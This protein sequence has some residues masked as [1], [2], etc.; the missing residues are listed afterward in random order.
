MAARRWGGGGGKPGCWQT[1]EHGQRR[2]PPLDGA[3]RKEIKSATSVAMVRRNKEHGAR[4]QS[5]MGPP[6]GAGRRAGV[7][8]LTRTGARGEHGAGARCCNPSGA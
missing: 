3:H 1:E 2:Q 5:N 4:A 6:G 8:G 7:P